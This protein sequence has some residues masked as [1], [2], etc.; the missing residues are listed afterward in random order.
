MTDSFTQRTK[1]AKD[2]SELI[3][4]V[5]P[6]LHYGVEYNAT[7]DINGNPALYNDEWIAKQIIETIRKNRQLL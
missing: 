4:L 3:R 2:D 7:L 1:Q 5:L 6:V